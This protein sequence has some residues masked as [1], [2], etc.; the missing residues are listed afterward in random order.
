MHGAELARLLGH[1][2]TGVDL[3]AASIEKAKKRLA[4]AYVADVTAPERYPFF[5]G[6]PFDVILFSDMLEHLSDPGD[7]LERHLALLA[8][9]GHVVI[10]LP[11][12]AIW[13]VRMGLFF[14]LFQYTDTGTLDRTHLRFFTRRSLRQFVA[15]AGLAIAGERLTPGIARPFVPLVKKLYGKP[16]SGEGDSGSIMESGP[17]RAYLKWL[18]PVERLFCRLRP[19]LLAFQ[20]VL[21]TRPDEA[22]AGASRRYSATQL[23]RPA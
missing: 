4:S 13:N 14:G 9:G 5:G 12:V 7:V 8:P 15:D 10:S 19:Q 6:E 11:N 20:F 3:S 21:L 2:V 18:Y 1:K 16:G 22:R 17:Y 23:Q